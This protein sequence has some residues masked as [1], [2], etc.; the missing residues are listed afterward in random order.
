[1]FHV[2]WVH[3]VVLSRCYDKHSV[4]LLSA[5]CFRQITQSLLHRS[6]LLSFVSPCQTLDNQ[7]SFDTLKRFAELRPTEKS[8]A[9]LPWCQ[10]RKRPAHSRTGSS[11]EHARQFV[12]TFA[13]FAH[14]CLMCRSVLL[15]HTTTLLACFVSANCCVSRTPGTNT[16]TPRQILRQPCDPRVQLQQWCTVASQWMKR[17]RKK[18]NLDGALVRDVYELYSFKVWSLFFCP[19]VQHW[20][21]QKWEFSSTSLPPK[22]PLNHQQPPKKDNFGRN[23]N[24]A[25]FEV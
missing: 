2:V 21:G 14:H 1:M 3:F 6:V 17:R 11:P 19:K 13:I 24:Y 23:S 4:S 12:P 8:E 5:V 16:T 18:R 25:P 9:L 15:N 20:Q 22:T 10:E 7:K